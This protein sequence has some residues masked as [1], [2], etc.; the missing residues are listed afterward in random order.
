MKIDIEGQQFK[1]TEQITYWMLKEALESSI[2]MR[3]CNAE[4]WVNLNHMDGLHQK[5]I[6]L[7][8]VQPVGTAELRKQALRRWEKVPDRI[9]TEISNL[10]FGLSKGYSM[11]KVIVKLVIEQLNKIQQYTIEE[12]PFM[13]PAL[14]D[15]DS[16]FIA[17]W[18]Q[19]I[20]EKINPTL[21]QYTH[22]LTSEYLPA[23]R[24]NVSVLALPNGVQC[25]Q[26]HIR[27][28]TTLSIT[29]EEIFNQGTALVS[30]N[31]QKATALGK[32][33]YQLNDL[34]PIIDKIKKD[35]ANYFKTKEEVLDFANRKL[36]RSKELSSSWFAI[37]PSKEVVL[38]PLLEHEDQGARYFPAN[39]SE[40]AYFRISLQNP[41]HLL[42]G[43][44]E[45]TA[46]HE[47]YPGHHLQIGVAQDIKG[48][49]PITKITFN[50]AFI[51][52]WARYSEQ[53][54]EE[55]GL[56]EDRTS[57]VLRLAWP[58][59]GMV[60]DPGIH[61]R[62]WSLEEVTKICKEAGVANRG[63]GV[64]YRSIVLPGQLTTYDLGGE[65]F[66]AL[67]KMAEDKLKES[68]DIRDFHSKLLENGPV[69]LPMLRRNIEKW[70]ESKSTNPQIR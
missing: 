40:P 27:L 42:K 61:L 32:E 52:G 62:N 10:R 41:H 69:P 30:A 12:S 17:Q 68:F 37:L 21:N 5:F 46:I 38:K 26:A 11:P 15:G 16:L 1:Q 24:D 23:A 18:K 22:F 31:A 3:Q 66:K 14:R 51:E 25:Y 70:I 58:A 59:R 43:D 39:G 20:L 55:M 44:A 9:G 13:S 57:L 4:L 65:E 19:L 34:E 60:I 28:L 8:S 45:I 2:G 64:Y 48:L 63:A 33:L 67:R 29:P 49:H 54:A 36:M 35:S 53:L 7:A 47:A 50:S 6:S 56:Y